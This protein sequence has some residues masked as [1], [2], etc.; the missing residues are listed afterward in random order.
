M[1]NGTQVGQ[2]SRLIGLT[3]SWHTWQWSICARHWETECSEVQKDGIKRKNNLRLGWLGKVLWKSWMLLDVVGWKC[4]EKEPGRALEGKPTPSASLYRL[5]HVESLSPQ[6]PH[7]CQSCQAA[8]RESK[9]CVHSLCLWLAL[10]NKA[11]RF[12]L[13]YTVDS[14]LGKMST[15]ASIR[16]TSFVRNFVAYL[17]FSRELSHFG[18]IKMGLHCIGEEIRVQKSFIRTAS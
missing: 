12:G 2:R 11:G 17:S 15:L 3:Q 4:E 14:D 9:N 8:N 16:D 7:V 13:H 1:S 5:F 6:G 18:S 10:C